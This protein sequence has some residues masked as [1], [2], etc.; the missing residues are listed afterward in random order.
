MADGAALYREVHGAFTHRVLS[1][2]PGLA[3]PAC[4]AWTVR[5]LLAHQAH[6]LAGMCDGS[7]PIADAMDAITASSPTERN[8]AAARQQRWIEEGISVRRTSSIS[9]LADEW[10]ALVE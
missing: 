1:A 5:E 7:F 8:A 10:S 6:Q 4:P 9:A 3:V 2:E